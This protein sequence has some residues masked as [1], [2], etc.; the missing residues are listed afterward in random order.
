MQ[1]SLQKVDD[2][3]DVYSSWNSSSSAPCDRRFSRAAR[4]VLRKHLLRTIFRDLERVERHVAFSSGYEDETVHI[5]LGRWLTSIPSSYSLDSI[6]TAQE[7]CP[8]L[9]QQDIYKEDDAQTR[10]VYIPSL[11]GGV[12]KNLKI[13]YPQTV[14]KYRRRHGADDRNNKNHPGYWLQCGYCLKTFISQFYLDIHL[15]TH[16]GQAQQDKVCPAR[17]WCKLVGMSN[18]HH[19]ALHDEPFYDRGSAGWGKDSSSAMIHHKWTKIAHSIPCSVA[20][21]RNDCQSVLVTCGFLDPNGDAQDDDDDNWAPTSH[22]GKL[23]YRFC[24]TLTCPPQQNL[25]QFLED[26]AYDFF[27][28]LTSTTSIPSAV[29]F[30]AQWESLWRRE[31]N[32]HTIL[33]SWMGIMVLLLLS[34]WIL[35]TM[36]VAARRGVLPA[37]NAIPPGQRLLYK[38][39]SQYRTSTTGRSGMTGPRTRPKQD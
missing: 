31:A 23:A 18:C 12:N 38:R 6:E 4:E 29:S 34:F 2:F 19:Q 11:P 37:R 14:L 10:H 33:F 25:W 5:L 27:L 8:L 20:Q 7:S 9:P 35:R 17:Q 15:T 13:A 26:E 28:G 36:L 32:H 21:L 16:H 39:G 24:Q 30:E 1:Y 22:H 3:P